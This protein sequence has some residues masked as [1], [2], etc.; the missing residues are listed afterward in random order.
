MENLT[1]EQIEM[2]LKRRKMIEKTKSSMG[3]LSGK[4]INYLQTNNEEMIYDIKNYLYEKYMVLFECIQNNNIP[5]NMINNNYYDNEYESRIYDICGML[6]ECKTEHKCEKK[7]LKQFETRLGGDDCDEDH[8]QIYNL[9]KTL[10]IKRQS[11]I[12][13]EKV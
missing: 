11:N 9:I 1:T 3:A 5:S 6:E 10:F 2:E 12:P 13:L 4:F 8:K 7:I